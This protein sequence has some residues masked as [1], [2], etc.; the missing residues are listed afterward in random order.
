MLLQKRLRNLSSNGS[1][2]DSKSVFITFK[3]A[4]ISLWI[5]SHDLSITD[6]QLRLIV[7]K[8]YRVYVFE[9]FLSRLI[10]LTTAFDFTIVQNIAYCFYDSKCGL[11]FVENAQYNLP[12]AIAEEWIVSSLCC[13]EN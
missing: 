8:C 3:L 1:P 13:L 5:A 4:V 11:S 2:F 9:S 10:G 12:L 7:F 6:F